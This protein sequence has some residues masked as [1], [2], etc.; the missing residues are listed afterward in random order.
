MKKYSGGVPLVAVERSG[1]DESWHHGSVV[2]LSAD[3]DVLASA[4]DPIGPIFP[5]SSNKPFQAIG[6]V[7]NGLRVST[8][9]LALVAASHSA[10]DMHLDGVRTLLASAGL[11]ESDLRCPPVDEQHGPIHM[12]CSGKHTG[13]LLTC[14]ANGWS[15]HDYYAPSHPLQQRILATIE[16]CASES[17][18]AVGVDGCGAPVAA[19]SL[20]GLATGFLRTATHEVADAIRAYPE[21][22]SGTGRDDALLMRAVPGLYCKGGAEGVWAAAVPGV[23]AVALKIDDGARRA[24]GPVMVSALK[25]LGITADLPLTPVLGRGAPVGTLRALW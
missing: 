10:E 21:M 24:C 8:R 25:R 16:E 22:M 9:D 15:I 19:F 11:T 5:R 12:N 3:G 14:V 2:V 13:M 17:V 20:T 23:G 4:G 7:R 6:M 1:F 18:A